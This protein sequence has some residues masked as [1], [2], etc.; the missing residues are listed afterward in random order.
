MKKAIRTI[1]EMTVG[2]AWDITLDMIT[3]WVVINAIIL[4]AVVLGNALSKVLI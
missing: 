4:G 3:S 1:K 2:E